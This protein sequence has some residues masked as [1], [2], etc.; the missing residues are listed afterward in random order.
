MI[1]RV[2]DGLSGGKALP[3]HEVG[4]LVK[5]GSVFLL[6]RCYCWDYSLCF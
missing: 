1:L 6:I 2:F 5:R 3:I 4:G